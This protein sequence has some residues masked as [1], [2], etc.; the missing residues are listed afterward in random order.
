M[1][2]LP[3]SRKTLFLIS[4]IFLIITLPI[5]IFL[6]QKNQENRTHASAGTTLKLEIAA[7]P[8]KPLRTVGDPVQIVM[9]IDPGTQNIIS[10]VS[11]DITYD[12]TK[13]TPNAQQPFTLNASLPAAWQPIAPVKIDSINGKITGTYTVSSSF[14][15]AIQ[16][17]SIFGTF[18]FT[19]I[20]STEGQN[21]IVG[22]SNTTATYSIG[23]ADTANENVLA[24]ATP[25]QFSIASSAV[26]TPIPAC[27]TT[28]STNSDCQGASDG[29]TTCNTSFSHNLCC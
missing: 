5:F 24:T 1:I 25:V 2:S 15:Q 8:T 6:V 23:T 20:A 3:L 4:T 18:A 11:F 26:P 17:P 9:S 7:D 12:K 16:K 10:V 21:T 14:T 28:C 27:N 29:C 13:L 22:F 19:T